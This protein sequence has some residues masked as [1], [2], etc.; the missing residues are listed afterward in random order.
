MHDSLG[1]QAAHSYGQLVEH[2]LCL[3][4]AQSAPILLQLLEVSPALFKDEVVVIFILSVVVEFANI[5]R[6]QVTISNSS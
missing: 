5:L 4:L 6:I 1:L 3:Y 2:S